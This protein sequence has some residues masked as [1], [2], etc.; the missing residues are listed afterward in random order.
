VRGGGGERK[1]CRCSE[2]K[3]VEPLI[4]CMCFVMAPLPLHAELG[5]ASPK[6]RKGGVFLDLSKMLRMPAGSDTS[7]G[8][9]V[10][11]AS[12][13][14]TGDLSEVSMSGRGGDRDATRRWGGGGAE[15]KAAKRVPELNLS[16]RVPE[17][18]LSSRVASGKAVH[19]GSV[20]QSGQA[21]TRHWRE[22]LERVKQ[23]L[24]ENSSSGLSL[25]AAR[26]TARG[27]GSGRAAGL[28]RAV[29]EEEE[30]EEEEESILHPGFAQMF[31]LQELAKTLTSPVS[32]RESCICVRSGVCV[33]MRACIE[34]AGV[35]A[36]YIIFYV[37]C[38]PVVLSRNCKTR[39]SPIQILA[40]RKH[41]QMKEFP[42]TST[43][44][45]HTHT[46]TLVVETDTPLLL[47][48]PLGNR[49]DYAF[50][51]P[52]APLKPSNTT[53]RRQHGR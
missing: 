50:D 8:A 29:K 19:D 42:C 26:D 45:S 47:S 24:E 2:V 20:S 7:D 46:H 39:L 21:Q 41:T 5:V 36:F 23:V 49:A 34:P 14:A 3:Q 37:R 48:L 40:P 15:G 16:S 30:E 22:D 43:Q 52:A 33:C 38:C 9:A 1:G 51:Y 4:V 18:N 27:E 17:L 44:K 25:A 12:H 13:A 53:G 6:P 10:S 28:P 35:L 11:D 31:Q 32:S